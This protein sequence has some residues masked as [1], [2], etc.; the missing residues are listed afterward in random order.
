MKYSI[1]PY[2]N[3][4]MDAFSA[5]YSRSRVKIAQFRAIPTFFK[6]FLCQGHSTMA[7]VN[8]NSAFPV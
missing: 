3:I 1:F 7:I 5:L 8:V 4:G 6:D 2:T